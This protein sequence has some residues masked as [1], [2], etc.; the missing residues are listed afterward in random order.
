MQ[1]V[2]TANKPGTLYLLTVQAVDDDG[3]VIAEGKAKA[4]CKYV[5]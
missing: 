2:V 4:S 3:G 5:R 1:A